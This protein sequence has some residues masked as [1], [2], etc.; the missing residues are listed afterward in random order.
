METAKTLWI[1]FCRMSEKWDTLFTFYARDRDDAERQAG[2]ILAEC[3]YERVDLKAYPSG[4]RI[5]LTHIPG[6]IEGNTI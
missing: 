5:V 1:L 6:M 3:G 2:E 4:F